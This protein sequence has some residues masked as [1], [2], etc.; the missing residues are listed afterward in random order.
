MKPAKVPIAA[1]DREMVNP[2]IKI[3]VEEAYMTHAN[4]LGKPATELNEVEKRQAFLNAT[5]KVAETTDDD[6]L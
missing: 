4:H 1:I 3:D 6:S 2:Y 5:L